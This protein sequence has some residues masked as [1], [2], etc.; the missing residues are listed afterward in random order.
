MSVLTSLIGGIVVLALVVR[1]AVAF[2]GDFS[3][4]P[5]SEK[6]EPKQ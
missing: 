2:V 5:Q 4:K 3:K 1:G 6:Q